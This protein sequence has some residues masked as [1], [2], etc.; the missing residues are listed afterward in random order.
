MVG[1]DV[2]QRRAARN[3]PGDRR[4]TWRQRKHDLPHIVGIKKPRPR[5]T[6]GKRD[7]IHQRKLGQQVACLIGQAEK[8]DIAERGR[9]VIRP[10]GHA[11][12]EYKHEPR[13][14]GDRHRNPDTVFLTLEEA[15]NTERAVGK[16][17]IEQNGP[18]IERKAA[19]EHEV[20][21]AVDDA[22]EKAP[23]RTAAQADYNQAQNWIDIITE[24][25]NAYE[26]YVSSV[27]AAKL[28]QQIYQLTLETRNLVDNEYNAGTALVT[29]VNQAETA[30]VQAQNNLATAI[31]NISNAQAQLDAAIYGSMQLEEES[32]NEKNN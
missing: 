10:D 30:L 27:E 25:R 16:Q 1:P 7:Y 5:H 18:E 32:K 11:G 8:P 24:V 13:G 23:F 20:E 14:N 31:V 17:V 29:R 6:H 19:V 28:S 15:R 12:E 26:N 9:G 3:H 22:A 4:K 2:R 21:D